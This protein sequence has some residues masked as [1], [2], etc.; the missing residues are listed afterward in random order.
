MLI[1][2]NEIKVGSNRREALP[3]DVSAIFLPPWEVKFVTGETRQE[4]RKPNL[5]TMLKAPTAKIFC[6]STNWEYAKWVF[7]SSFASPTHWRFPLCPLFLPSTLMQKQKLPLVMR[8]LM[9]NTENIL[10]R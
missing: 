6:L 3:E 8:S 2:I 1:N 10:T 9:K 7:L 5:L 4:N